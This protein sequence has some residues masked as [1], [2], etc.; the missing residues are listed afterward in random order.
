MPRPSKP[1]PDQGEPFTT[2]RLTPDETLAVRLH[3][4][5]LTDEAIAQNLS[6]QHGEDGPIPPAWV[7]PAIAWSQVYGPGR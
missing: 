5:G 2:P 6:D 7:R 1:N 4:T 3:H